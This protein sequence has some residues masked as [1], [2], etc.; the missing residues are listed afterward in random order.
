MCKAHTTKLCREVC[1]LAR[2][3]MGGNGIVLENHAMKQM[4][5]IEGV[6]SYEGTYEINAL[7]AGREM[8]GFAAFR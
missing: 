7:V 5:D 2:E 8:T 4:L 3:V 6:Y 1:A